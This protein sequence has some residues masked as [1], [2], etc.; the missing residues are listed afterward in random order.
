MEQEQR[1][2][3]LKDL[4]DFLDVKM[5]NVIYD[6]EQLSLDSGVCFTASKVASKILRKL[7]FDCE[8]QRMKLVIGNEGGIKKFNQFLKDGKEPKYVGKEHIIGLGYDGWDG[9]AEGGS[10]YVVY[11]KNENL[12][13]DLTIGQATRPEKDILMKPYFT[14]P[15]DRPEEIV[16][17]KFEK[18]NKKYELS[19][20]FYSAREYYEKVINEGYRELKKRWK[21]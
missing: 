6:G 14:T 13:M 8:V 7:G 21:R 12:I 5:K 10:H 9:D 15:E 17:Y 2:E 11:F 20:S 3:L 4:Y 16:G 18:P 19:T 1:N